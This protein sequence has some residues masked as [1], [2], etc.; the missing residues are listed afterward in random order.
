MPL[1]DSRTLFD[2]LRS[3]AELHPDRCA[4]RFLLNGE[5]VEESLTFGSLARQAQGLA[6]RLQNQAAPGERVL[7][8]LGSGAR[9]VVGFLACLGAGLVAVPTYPPRGRRGRERFRSI[10]ASAGPRLILADGEEAE[11]LRA[12]VGESGVSV[13]S[14]VRDGDREAEEWAAKWRPPEGVGADSLAFL[15]YTS[16]STSTPKGVCVTHGNL[17]H[18]EELIRRAFRMSPGETSSREAPSGEVPSGKVPSTSRVLGWL[19][20]YHDMGLIG[21]ALQP[22]YVGCEAVLMSPVDFVRRPARWLRA[23][24][25]FAAD[26]SGGPNFAYDLCTEKIADEEMEGVDLSHWRVAFNG[27]EPIRAS[28]LEAFSRRFGRWGFTRRA[29]VPCYGLAEATLLVSATPDDWQPTTLKVSAASLQRGSVSPPT[30]DSERT[31]VSS[32]AVPA[33]VEVAI[34]DPETRRRRQRAA[35][36]EIWLRSASNAVGYW[37]LPEL[38][39]EVFGARLAPNGDGGYLRTGDLGFLEEGQLYV[40]GRLKEL[41]I[42]RGRNLYP[43]DIE[44]SAQKSTQWSAPSS[45]QP[46]SEVEVEGATAALR[47][48]AAAAFSVENDG[49]ECLVLVA[50][51][52]RHGAVDAEA[53]GR[54]IR[55]VVAE[56]HEVPLDELVLIRA[57]SLPKTTSGK[58]RRRETRRRFLAGELWVV[59]RSLRRSEG[60]AVPEPMEGLG[61]EASAEE[62][63]RRE[64]ARV[65][66]ISP[67]QVDASVP[68]T[69]LGLDSLTAMELA[70][71]VEGEARQLPLSRLLDGWNL[72]DVAAWLAEAIEEQSGEGESD[73]GAAALAAHRE[74]ELQP[75]AER[76]AAAMTSA[77]RS[78]WFLHR[79][80][81][82]S[83]A[84]H[85]TAA[86]SLRAGSD[87]SAGST[88]SSNF[89]SVGPAVDAAALERAVEAL[90][91]RHPALRCAFP[92]ATSVDPVRRVTPPEAVTAGEVFQRVEVG[93]ESDEALRWRLQQ[94]A[95]RPFDMQR[96]PLLRIR[97]YRRS[98]GESV[99]LWVL[100]HIVGDLRSLAVM[101]RELGV[102]YEQE[103]RRQGT[104]LEALGGQQP[105]LAAAGDEARRGRALDYW[106]R[107]LTTPLPVL[108]LPSEGARPRRGGR[109]RRRLGG[110]LKEAFLERA[111]ATGATPFVAFLSLYGT[112]LLRLTDSEEVMV[113]V[114]SAGRDLPALREAVD[115][116]VRPLPLR[117]QGRRQAPW[118]ETLERWR[119]EVLD[120]L[121][122]RELDLVALARELGGDRH[123]APLF[124]TFFA[125]QA[126]PPGAPRGLAAV[127]AGEGEEA[128]EMGPLKLRSWDLPPADPR[129]DLALDVVPTPAGAAV[130]ALEFDAGQ[131]EAVTVERFLRQLES[132]ARAVVE[133]PRRS[134]G[135]LPLLGRGERHQLLTAWNDTAASAVNS[136][137]RGGFEPVHHKIFAR[138]A[139]H[140]LR[141]AVVAAEGSG[142]SFAE[143]S[144]LTYGELARQARALARGLSRQRLGAETPVALRLE[145]GPHLF[146]VLL[147]ILESGL[148][149]L[150]LDSRLPP[151]RAALM[152][153]DAG[154]PLLIVDDG[155]DAA[156]E[157]LK[158][159]WGERPGPWPR[160]LSWG[161]L[162]SAE[163]AETDPEIEAP[164]SETLAPQR[165][166]YLLYTSGSTGRPKGVAIPHGALANFLQSMAR[167]PGVGAEDV[168]LA[169]TSLS[170]DIS[171]LEVLL[172]LTVGARVAWVD[173]ATAAD[174][175]RLSA[176]LAAASVTVMQA[177]PSSWRML[178][179]AGWKAPSG[180]R[181]FSGGEPLD[182]ALAERLTAEASELWN[183]YGPT[184]TTVWST[185]APLDKDIGDAAQITLGRPIDNTRVEI[186]D[187]CGAAVALGARGEI[188]LGGSGLARGYMGLPARTA[189]RFRPDPRTAGGRRYWTGD[190]GRWSADGRLRF[191]GRIDHQVKVR[192]HRLE[193]GEIE[194]ALTSAR[195]IDQAAVL[196]RTDVAA[197]PT[198]V[199]YLRASASTRREATAAARWAVFDR[200]PAPAHPGLYV[201]LDEMPLTASG[202]VDRHRL[203]APGAGTET[204]EP[205][206]E[207]TPV[208]ALTAEVWREVLGSPPRR[209]AGFFDSG[210]HSLAAARMASRLSEALAVEVPVRILFEAPT[211]EALARRLESLRQQGAGPDLD[212]EDFFPLTATSGAAGDEISPVSPGQ[213]ELWRR[214]LLHPSSP[215]FNLPMTLEL[216]GALQ[217]RALAAA[218]HG[219]EERHDLLRACFADHDGRP[220]WTLAEPR[221]LPAV[222]LSALDSEAAAE[223]RRLAV[224]EARRPFEVR[225]QAPLWRTVLVRLTPE[226]HQLLLC[227]HHMVADGP[228]AAI[229]LRDWAQLYQRY[230]LQRRGEGRDEAG[231]A[232][233]PALDWAAVAAWQRVLVDGQGDEW[234][235]E[236]RGRLG[237]AQ[238]AA[239]NQ[240][241]PH[242]RPVGEGEASGILRRRLPPNFVAAM[243]SL[244]RRHQVSPLM[245]C[246]AALAVLLARYGGNASVAVMTPVGQRDREE[247]E[248][249]LG[250]L[251]NLLPAHLELRWDRPV[252]ELLAAARTTILDLWDCRWLPPSSLGSASAGP[253]ITLAEERWPAPLRLDDLEILATARETATAKADLDWTLHHRGSSSAQR[254]EISLAFRRA[255]FDTTTAERLLRQWIQLTQQIVA[256]PGRPTG[257]LSPWSCA[258]RHQCWVEW[259]AGRR[260]DSA[261]PRRGVLAEIHHWA[262]LHPQTLALS[263]DQAPGEEPDR[264]AAGTLTY[265]E[266]VRRAGSIARSLERRGVGAEHRVAVVMESSSEL[267]LTWMAVM[268]AGAAYVAID[269]AQP[270]GRIASILESSG[271]RWLV[272]DGTLAAALSLEQD[273]PVPPDLEVLTPQQL[274][275]DAGSCAVGPSSVQDDSAGIGFRDTGAPTAEALAYVIF[276]SGSSGRPKGV[277][278]SHRGLWNLVR[279]HRRRYPL[280]PGHRAT[281]LAGL[282][283]DASVWEVWPCL[284][285]GGCLHLGPTQ[286]RTSPEQLA[287]WLVERRIA[288]TF[289]P[290]PMAEELMGAAGEGLRDGSLSFVLTGGDRLHGAPPEGFG[291][292]V[293]NHYGPTENAVVATAGVVYRDSAR[294]RPPSIGSPIQGVE[295]LVCG[296]D[297]R[298]LGP[299]AVGELCIAGESLARGYLDSPA[300]T[301]GVFRPHPLAVGERIYHSGDAVRWDAAGELHFLERLDDQV[302]LRG[303]RIELGEVE[304][305]LSSHPGVQRT[306]VRLIGEGASSFLVGYAVAV[307]AVESSEQELRDWL[308]QRLPRAMVP[309][310][311]LF[312]H[313]LPLTSNG[314]IDRRRLPVPQPRSEPV[315]PRSDLEV[316]LLAMWEELLEPEQPLGVL[317]DFFALGGHSL[318]VTRL[319]ARVRD[320]FGA[321][322]TPARFV[323]SPTVAAL[324]VAVAEGLMAA[325]SAEELNAALT[326]IDE[327]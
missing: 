321:E 20:L 205:T 170:F 147:G 314:K 106:R 146:V 76:G 43:Q 100:H 86:G 315:A 109:L 38:S 119:R 155:G 41:I 162:V 116:L 125:Y 193:L 77:Q 168:V 122:H 145:P 152:M 172:P 57:H 94:E 324:S 201:L 23:V 195:E 319:L 107:R 50:E 161:K 288:L 188:T 136:W 37:E 293:V 276:T 308:S 53:L 267:I 271:T 182:P 68:L 234:V 304:A 287:R 209:G 185:V 58:I 123:E 130:L 124:Q 95:R 143:S 305:A 175:Q 255:R 108:R 39:V 248:G 2:L 251:V 111:A 117:L 101:A 42:L 217:P 85:L 178:L 216:S 246:L 286:V 114:P 16:G 151:A 10:L 67:Q 265:G 221:P 97:L 238:T 247:L 243:E 198:L 48:G 102:A 249:V 224:R 214:Q 6:A 54:A 269:P 64:V 36:G 294:H 164:Q 189:E 204:A 15:Q 187:R 316:A 244:G 171:L 66:E 137:G 307:P 289:V 240:R 158:G 323:A 250:Y 22:L 40:T 284:A 118:E 46:G 74:P 71:A 256:D 80:D 322:V 110:A 326:E 104:A 220:R 27:S 78:L 14:G 61:E 285:A 52:E 212:L 35:V 99:L 149:F 211:V 210:G 199:A 167:R 166:A 103:V 87:R 301:A 230:Q 92:L 236:I 179:F 59:G 128:L 232:A 196:L 83:S 9:F 84:Y 89:P 222:D 295:A 194:T 263:W 45:T 138:A 33:G 65:L 208:A 252:E 190:R 266:L 310:R 309:T 34:V 200:L 5:T 17:L 254:W 268:A 219:L 163:G 31:L 12:L 144:G 69:A 173:S 258:Q 181:I 291:V 261:P 283:F 231:I 186:V 280:G 96:G 139:M 148:S 82:K 192:G 177:T 105:D 159:A 81:P 259:N 49:G 153:A 98:G 24:S 91:R 202:K 281:Q 156:V 191:E 142:L 18:N 223:A 131:L 121:D 262:Q 300:A 299:G 165:L 113:G 129:F 312:L 112:W 29:F 317:D 245:I 197:E 228:S 227:A 70:A 273:F 327:S 133:D 75:E 13:L 278:V 176:A 79:L 11:G 169:H 325:L 21:N 157:E 140:P 313:S 180:L 126:P 132:L 233:A 25:E 290:T 241:L 270:R 297:G 3:R 282:G 215:A 277:G 303:A 1:E 207:T 302:Q 28:T 260:V 296:V 7:L 160:V 30:D 26:T 93:G 55:R 235:A 320:T 8:S 275:S 318:Q 47:R 226:R 274:E 150:P 134:L 237:K 239:L 115:Y 154:V 213:E 292:T 62:R 229:L 88:D 44:A 51:V 72:K 306:A 135:S 60:R 63:L 257:E 264:R 174:G 56:E 298:P 225:G 120:A 90:V 311:I 32:G 272:T 203:P 127:A 253:A 218:L 19:P 279:W 4:Y 184:E 183:L 141:P 73:L 206:A 242:D